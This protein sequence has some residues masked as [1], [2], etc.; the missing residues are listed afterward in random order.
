MSA[1]TYGTILFYL[2]DKQYGYVRLQGTREEFH[3]RYKNLRYE[4][5]QAGD[6]VRFRI[7]RTAQGYVADRIEKAPLT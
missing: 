5:P 1:P 3:F 6:L 4:D 2:E 7:K